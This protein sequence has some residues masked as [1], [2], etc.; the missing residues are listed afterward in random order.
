MYIQVLADKILLLTSPL[1]KGGLVWTYHT[2]AFWGVLTLAAEI[3]QKFNP[4]HSNNAKLKIVIPG[5]L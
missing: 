3:L 1:L 5:S 4:I 2:E